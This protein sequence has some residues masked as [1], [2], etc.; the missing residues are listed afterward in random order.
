MSQKIYKTGFGEEIKVGDN[1]KINNSIHQIE[2][3]EVIRWAGLIATY[4]IN[5]EEKRTNV[6][7]YKLDSE[8]IWVHKK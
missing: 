3:L 6:S 8:K 5:G 7:F 4:Q 2:K 1:L